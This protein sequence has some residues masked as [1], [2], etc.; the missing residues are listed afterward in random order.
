MAV[1]SSSS[2][3]V[4]SSYKY[5][6]FISFRGEDT[7]KNFTSHLSSALC[8]NAIEVY[9]DDRLERGGEISSALLTAIEE[10]QLSL[11]VFSKD[12]ASSR[13]CLD[14]L[15]HILKCKRERGQIVL[16]VFY[17]V[18]PSDIRHQR[19]SYGAAFAAHQKRFK[20][21]RIKVEEWRNAL[22]GATAL[23][24]FHLQ[25]ESESEFVEKIVKNVI[26]KLENVSSS[27]TADDFQGQLVGISKRLEKMESLLCI[28]SPNV[29]VIGIWGMGGIGKTTLAEALYKRVSPKFDTC[30]F[31][32]VKEEVLKHGLNGLKERLFCKLLKCERVNMESSFK[33]VQLWRKRVLVVLDNVDQL[34]QLECLFGE[35][36]DVSQEGNGRFGLGSRIIV[37]SRD[38][39]LLTSRAD[40]IYEVDALDSIEARRLFYLKAFRRVSA[41]STDYTDLAERVLDYAKGNPLALK[42]LGSHLHSRSI[43]EWKSATG[44]LK[45]AP[46]ETIQGVLKLSYDA[47]DRI[48]KSI[49]LDIACLLK[50]EKRNFI[51]GILDEESHIGI[52]VLIEKSLITSGDFEIIG[53]H[54]LVQ[55]MGWEIV[56]QE[57]LNE[58]AER[59]RLWIAQDVVHVL[60]NKKGTKS[61]IG[62]SLDLSKIDEDLWLEPT[63]FETMPNLRLLKIYNS[64]H[65]N[66]LQ[67]LEQN[68]LLNLKRLIGK[69]C[70]LI[71]L[72]KDLR[73]LPNS[74][75]YLSWIE[76]PSKTLPIKFRP[77]SLVELEMPYSQLTQLWDGLQPLGNL[78]H[79]DFSFSKQL[80]KFP[81]LSHASRLESM[82][83]IGCTS[84]VEIPPLNFQVF[85]DLKSMDQISLDMSCDKR[86][87]GSLDLSFCTNL[88]SL[89]EISGNL[90]ILHLIETEIKELPSSIR[91]L[92]NLDYLNLVG[93]ENLE[94]FPELPRNIQILDLSGTAI[95]EMPTTSIERLHDVKIILMSGC[96]RLVSLPSNL[97]KCKALT[98]LYLNGCSNLKNFPEI[99]EPMENLNYLS[100]EETGIQ[101]L[102][103]SFANIIGLSGLSIGWCKNLKTI[104]KC[105]NTLS[106]LDDL[107]LGGCW[108]L[109]IFPDM[110]LGLRSLKEVNLRYC[111]ISEIP[112]WIGSL[113]SLTSLDLT[114]NMFA[115]I[116][117]S[118]KQLPKLYYLAIS[119]CRN[120][121]SLPEL[122]SSIEQ[123]NADGCLSMETFLISRP[124][125]TWVLYPLNGVSFM[126]CECLKL[127]QS[128]CDIMTV[129]FLCRVICNAMILRLTDEHMDKTQRIIEVCYPGNRIPKW[130]RYQSEGSSKL[131]IKL[132]PNWDRANFSGFVA[133]TVLSF[134]ELYWNR[135]GKVAIFCKVHLKTKQGQCHYWNTSC[136]LNTSVV[137]EDS[138]GIKGGILRSDHV[139]M[140]HAYCKDSLKGYDGEFDAAEMS[141]D[142][143]CIDYTANSY[144][145]EKHEC[146][147][148]YKVK[149]CGIHMLHA[150]TV[151]AMNKVFT[152]MSIKQCKKYMFEAKELGINSLQHLQSLQDSGDIEALE[153]G[154]KLKAMEARSEDLLTL[155]NVFSMEA[156]L[157]D[158]GSPASAPLMSDDT[159]ES[160]SQD[161]NIVLPLS[162][163]SESCP[164][165]AD[166]HDQVNNQS[167]LE[168]V[169]RFY[170]FFGTEVPLHD[171]RSSTS[172]SRDSSTTHEEAVCLNFDTE[173]SCYE[174]INCFDFCCWSNFFSKILEWFQANRG[175]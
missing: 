74:I 170:D 155:Y 76:Y 98:E 40:E 56:R 171:K 174:R 52:N 102:S 166:A 31:T 12:Y 43:S 114:G 148:Q 154:F 41:I 91:S 111:N 97:C 49:F 106:C 19:G 147:L 158:I 160:P 1:A 14:E 103:S 100:L 53:M 134:E 151:Q 7:R 30:F 136:H 149:R 73:Y 35:H 29:R 55:E 75:R 150:E 109:E 63:V 16:P 24:G 33:D 38:K 4:P 135:I 130:M 59:S 22:R 37:T 163:Y 108:K 140:W 96:K 26:E 8:R 123:L 125:H 119:H 145:T 62:I 88:T 9:I 2:S 25:D 144:S 89:P 23:S 159:I 10:S 121:R 152:N 21:H 156:S 93:C 79:I 51:E 32:N 42:V 94:I 131:T 173:D 132:P 36:H 95:R 87:F 118:I 168:T 117:S 124:T 61:V 80:A 71:Y 142:F 83:L 167:C 69:K 139:I 122:P 128:S 113:S 6:V 45:K 20:N 116:P 86:A 17:H 58:L 92:K 99:F 165:E 115:S 65:N 18:D 157:Y 27:A 72:H 5:D 48:E 85:D 127:D 82:C 126:F 175:N 84:L 164:P 129:N 47:L 146:S 101:E 60:E 161:T 90:K 153:Q 112:H 15:V 3:F 143:G 162:P 120:L 50:G 68:L 77:E 39:K 133:C 46:N 138:E 11:V 67:N 78:K 81:D 104:P 54:D 66:C 105:L 110:L 28:G 70:R 137:D 13:W 57:S 34:E 64:G 107:F 169:P 141:F 172:P 44:K